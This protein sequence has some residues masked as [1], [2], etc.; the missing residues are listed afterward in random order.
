MMRFKKVYVSLAVLTVFLAACGEQSTKAPSGTETEAAA[1][2]AM[3]Q[4]Q[5]QTRLLDAKLGD[6]IEIPEGFYSFDRSLSLTVD[7]V[8]IRGAGHDKTILSFKGQIAGAEGLLVTANDFTIEN[9]AI[10]DAK[11][12][13][14]KINEG[15]N[16]V[17]RG[18]RTE[19][20]NGPATDNGA[21]GIYPVQTE[22]VLIEDSIA[23]GASDA[24][25]YVGQSKNIIMRRNRAEYNVAGLEVENS[26]NAD[27]YDNVATNNTGGILVF[28][29]PNLQ[30][31]G[32]RTRVYNNQVFE[33]NLK[34]FAH[35]GA[36]VASVPAGTGIIISANDKVEIFNNTIK[37]NKT[38]NIV[39]SS[40]F[41]IGSMTEK[42]IKE[43]F[44]P[45]PEG[46]F[47]HDNIFEG[48]GNAP[49]PLELKALKLAMFG[50]KGHLP[51]IMWDG[52]I[53]AELPADTKRLCVQNGAAKVINVDGPG[54]YKKPSMDQSPYDCTMSRLPEVKF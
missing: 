29:L 16:I 10:E 2:T 8:T 52:Y 6:V 37:N 30:Q 44:D 35:K 11:G 5:L 24:G 33:N 19:W 22:N 38:S 20:T 43:S 15:K 54:G 39:I 17:I 46:I 49:A 1:K 40:Y 21:Y 9:L 32:E 7:G 53:N 25:I 34:N 45:Y 14:L 50:L 28:N 51:D 48:G 36:I 42:G 27:V 3:F 13:A 18:V 41:S 23:I 12:D 31:R 4:K 47:I 26:I